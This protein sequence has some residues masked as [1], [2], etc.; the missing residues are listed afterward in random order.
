MQAEEEKYIGT[1]LNND[2]MS[3]I[4]QYNPQNEPFG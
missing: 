3:C 4:K 1:P 2:I